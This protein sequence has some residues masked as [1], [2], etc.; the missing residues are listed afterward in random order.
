MNRR[1]APVG[2]FCACIVPVAAGIYRGSAIIREW[3]WM[4]TF[5]PERVDRIPLF[6]HVTASAIFY[7]LGALQVLPRFR[8][9][10][11]SW[12]R[13]A[14]KMAVVTGLLGA[15][16]STWMTAMHQGV[17][18]P[19]LMY[20]RLLFGPLWGLFIVLG[21]FA[22]RARDFRSHGAWMLR[23]F[24]VAMPAGT[25]IFIFLPFFLVLDEVPEVLDESLQSCAW[26]AHLLI[27]EWII[28]RK[29]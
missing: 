21:L 13:R 1:L 20:G 16:T 11:P 15:G 19:I 12:H 6:I 8:A 24:A 3:D 28:R 4:P 17:S 22:I 23:A 9:K 2:L 5:S 27:A 14:G 29:A 7:V 26:I 18:G 25:L 10:H